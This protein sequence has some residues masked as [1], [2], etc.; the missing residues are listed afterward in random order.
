MRNIAA[1]RHDPRAETPALRRSTLL[2]LLIGFGVFYGWDLFEAVANLAA[3]LGYAAQVGGQLS[4][5]AWIVLV[6]GIVFPVALF[7]AAVLLRRRRG[8]LVSALILLTGLA[9]SAV[10]SLDLEAL[11][12]NSGG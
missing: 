11:V 8:L 2:A 10:L 9:T 5:L 12:R 4:S 7:V 1:R 3:F 6:S